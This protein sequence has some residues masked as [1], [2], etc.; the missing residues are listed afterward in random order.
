MLKS[1]ALTV[2]ATALLTAPFAAAQCPSD[3]ARLCCSNTFAFSQDEADL[4]AC[5]IPTPSDPDFEE[6]ATQCV[7]FNGTACPPNTDDLCC[8][9]SYTC[10]KFN[11]P[12]GVSCG[13]D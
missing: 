4:N 3:F 6:V 7:M 11:G 2:L 9:K 13:P 1:T 10:D 12:V 8:V 5:G